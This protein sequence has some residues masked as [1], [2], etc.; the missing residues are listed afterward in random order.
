LC[1][2]SIST[3]GV[4]AMGVR[5]SG[6]HSGENETLALL[7]NV[8]ADATGRGGFTGGAG[9]WHSDRDSTLNNITNAG[10]LDI[11]DHTLTATGTL[12][13]TGTDTGAIH[14]DTTGDGQADSAAIRPAIDG[15]KFELGAGVDRQLSA[16]HQLHFD[17]EASYAEKYNK[18]W[19]L[20]AGY[21]FQ[22]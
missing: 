20:T 7:D 1:N 14:L 3:S 2:G 11:A 22:F 8:T 10:T 5:M 15:A 18:P 12:A 6:N 9:A 19:G 17:Y 4:L 16:A 21:R 13:I